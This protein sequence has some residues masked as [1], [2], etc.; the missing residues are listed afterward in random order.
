MTHFEYF[1]QKVCKRTQKVCV[2][3]HSLACGHPVD[4]APFV[5]DTVC[6]IVLPLLFCQRSVYCTFKKLINYLLA[7][8]S[9]L[10][11]KGFLL[12]LSRDH[13]SLRCAG[14]QASRCSGLSCCRARPVGQVGFSSCCAWAQ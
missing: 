4:P 6:S 13:F 3:V 9:P 10:L 7:V 8:L 5:E 1:L 14:L 12:A 11:H 2:Q